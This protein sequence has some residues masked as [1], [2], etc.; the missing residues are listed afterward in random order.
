M[1]VDCV[2]TSLYFIYDHT[3]IYIYT[4]KVNIKRDVFVRGLNSI[5]ASEHIIVYT[6]L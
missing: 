5:F 2:E 3:Y 6:L 1:R 4:Y